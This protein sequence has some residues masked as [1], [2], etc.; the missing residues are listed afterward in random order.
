MVLPNPEQEGTLSVFFVLKYIRSD[1][2]CWKRYDTFNQ[3]VCKVLSITTGA[4]ITLERSYT[5]KKSHNSTWV[6]QTRV[7]TI[8][9]NIHLHSVCVYI[10]THTHIYVAFPLLGPVFYNCSLSLPTL[11]RQGTIVFFQPPRELLFGQPILAL[12]TD[13]FLSTTQTSSISTHSELMH[14][15]TIATFPLLIT[16]TSLWLWAYVLS[17]KSKQN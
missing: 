2:Y 1:L 17:L 13:G 10:H 14:F 16:T 7:C 11:E 12:W 6:F 4:S 8:T 5:W 15:Y 3:T 9:T